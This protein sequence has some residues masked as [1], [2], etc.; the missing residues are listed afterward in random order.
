M[1]RLFFGNRSFVLLFLPIII[2]VLVA[3][4]HFFPIELPA[5][6]ENDSWWFFK[7]SEANGISQILAPLVVFGDA[8][9]I[10]FIF[11][12][13]G[14]KGRNTFI[15][16]LLYVGTHSFFH[17]FYYFSVYSILSTLL[18]LILHQMFRLDQNKDGRKQVFN[19]GF[20]LGCAAVLFPPIVLL[21]PFIQPSI[22]IHRPF[23]F[24]ENSLLLAGIITPI[25]YLWVFLFYYNLDFFSLLFDFSAISSQWIPL[26]VLGALLVIASLI[27]LPVFF[28]YNS[29]SSIKLK[30]N[31]RVLLIFLFSCVGLT[32]VEFFIFSIVEV[33][34]LVLIPFIFLFSYVFGTKKP[35]K[36][37]VFITYLIIVLSVGKGLIIQ[38]I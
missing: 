38:L 25:L 10:N 17:S 30:K 26:L 9:L 32:I 18:L 29:Q 35:R 37:S 2:G 34:Q 5:T 6:A 24:R 4:N 19:I 14:F 33:A 36:L 28:Q 7:W 3:I 11:N 20:F 27:H 23:I 12:K 13:N 31:I 15:P 1:I 21:Y 22:W 8:V 16:S